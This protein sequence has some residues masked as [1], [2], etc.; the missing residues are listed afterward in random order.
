MI[1]ISVSPICGPRCCRATVRRGTSRF[2]TV[3]YSVRAPRHYPRYLCADCH[4]GGWYDP[5]R[6]HCNVF[7]VRIDA[8]WTDALYPRRCQ[9]RFTY[10]KR[11]DAPHRYRSYKSTWSTKDRW[12]DDRGDH[13][14]RNFGGKAP[15]ERD[16]LV[17]RKDHRPDRPGRTTIKDARPTRSRGERDIDR[18]RTA[19]DDRTRVKNGRDRGDRGRQKV[20]RP[21]SDRGSDRKKRAADKPR[22]DRSTRDNGK[23]DRSRGD[24]GKSRNRR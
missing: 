14:V 4:V 1:R 3:Y 5:Y 20:D 23:A 13:L 8:W 18:S 17:A 16:H 2:G 19:R 24:R 12:T 22:R 11:S 10:W 6:D 21:R 15:R 7:D 9:P